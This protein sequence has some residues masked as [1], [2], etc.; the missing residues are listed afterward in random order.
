MEN[1]H[2]QTNEQQFLI[3]NQNDFKRLESKLDE[4]LRF[5][6]SSK[7][8]TNAIDKYMSENDTMQTLGKGKTWVYN[9]RRAGLL[10]YSKVGQTV[11]YETESVLKVLNGK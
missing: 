9:M 7:N 11:Y 4:I 5:Y 8:V 1:T 6:K 10:N 3:L 2:N